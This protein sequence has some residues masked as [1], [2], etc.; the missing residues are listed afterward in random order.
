MATRRAL[1]T[2]PSAHRAAEQARVAVSNARTLN[3]LY[4]FGANPCVGYLART[5][6]PPHCALVTPKRLLGTYCPTVAAV[7]QTL[8]PHQ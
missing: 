5:L 2:A 8:A 6:A 3:C 7:N 4:A 1:R